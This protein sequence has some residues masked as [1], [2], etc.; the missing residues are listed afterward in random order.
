MRD[1]G[2][3]H[4]HDGRDGAGS[5]LDELYATPPSAFVARRAELAAAAKAEGRAEDARA[6]RA[7]R[8]PTLAAWAANLLLRAEPEESR[9]FLRLGRS[10]REAYRTLDAAGLKELSARRRSVVAALSGQAARHAEDAGHRLSDAARR[11][12]EETLRAVLADPE[13]AER[14][15]T[16]R[17][18]RGL[19]PPS[20]FPM[21]STGAPDGGAGDATWPKEAPR[22]PPASR[23]AA[24]KAPARDELAERRRVR[25]E[26][27]AR[28]REAAREAGE[29]LDG[30]RA[31][32]ADTG[33]GLER[34]G[35]RVEAARERV[36]AAERALREARAELERAEGERRRAEEGHR[37]A[38]EALAE[39][40][41]EAHRTARELERSERRR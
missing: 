36:S 2:R 1:K 9:R 30:R 39:A 38:A 20:A 18:E 41:R 10:L 16:G 37:T 11:E 26:R 4:R 31:E 23:P 6:L 25:Q 12:V 5:A 24:K 29:R 22:P 14:W 27:L 28:A 15:A 34:A 19:T 40:E 33:A 21:G 17:L 7:A 8:R 35:E 3:G 32:E 13:A